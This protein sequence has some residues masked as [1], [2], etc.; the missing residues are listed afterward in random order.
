MRAMLF[1]D[2]AQRRLPI[3]KMKIAVTYTVLREKYL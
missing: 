1:G 2:R 3:S